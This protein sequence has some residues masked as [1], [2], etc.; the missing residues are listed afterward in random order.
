MSFPGDGSADV[1]PVGDAGYSKDWS[2]FDLDSNIALIANPNYLTS[3]MV[4][5][6]M[7][8]G[9]IGVIFYRQDRGGRYNGAISG[10]PK[11]PVL[12][13]RRVHGDSLM[14]EFEAGCSRVSWS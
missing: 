5:N 6:A 1:L 10:T 2:Q 14:S 9:A 7:K 3:Y 12:R 8:H 4:G 11:V 13:I